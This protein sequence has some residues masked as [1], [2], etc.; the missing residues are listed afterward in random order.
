MG[1]RWSEVGLFADI[2]L[3]I[4]PLQMMKQ[5]KLFGRFSSNRARFGRA[6]PWLAGLICALTAPLHGMQPVTVRWNPNVETDIAGYK[7]LVGSRSG[8]YERRY[9]VTDGTALVLDDLEVATEYFVAVQAYN[10]AGQNSGL[11]EEIRFSTVPSGTV[12]LQRWLAERGVSG[13]A[14]DDPDAD[15]LNHLQEFAFGTDPLVAGPE[16]ASLRGGGSLQRGAPVLGPDGA[17]YC[18]RADA[19]ASGLEYRPQVSTDL[20][21]WSVVSDPGVVVARDSEVELIYLPTP[22]S[23][24]ASGFLRIEVRLAP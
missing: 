2:S 13:N 11:S 19:L 5:M 15:G 7:V 9:T 17:W 22:I 16:R 20:R 10:F 3:E 1:L 8:D 6:S 12:A 24:Q 18:R 14:N 4:K 23:G 21:Q